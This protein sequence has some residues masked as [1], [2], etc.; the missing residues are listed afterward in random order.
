MSV[1]HHDKQRSVRIA[2]K[3]LEALTAEANRTGL[4]KPAILLRMLISEVVFNKDERGDLKLAEICNLGSEI[5]T[6][7]APDRLT[8]RFNEENNDQLQKELDKHA[9]G[10]FS[11]LVTGILVYR[12]DGYSQKGAS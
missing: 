10:Q 3:H 5:G 9:S 8:V 2:A 1:S 7:A 11:T 6:H 12:Y 4:G